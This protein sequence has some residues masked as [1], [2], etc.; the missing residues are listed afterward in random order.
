MK[1]PGLLLSKNGF[2]HGGTSSDLFIQIEI[3]IGIGIEKR[4]FRPPSPRPP[5]RG[6][7]QPDGRVCRS[8]VTGCRVVARHDKHLILSVYFS[9]RQEKYQKNRALRLGLRLPS[10][11]RFFRRGQ[12]LA[13]LR[14]AQTACPLVPE[15][16][17]ALGYAAKGENFHLNPCR[18]SKPLL[19][20]DFGQ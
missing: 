15:K 2:N 18:I 19:K 5:S 14:R 6:P 7:V 17:L 3:A 11:K 1:Y 13:R 8:S 10:R 20:A 16:P 4:L 12:E 9:C